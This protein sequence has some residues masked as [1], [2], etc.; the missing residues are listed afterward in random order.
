MLML[1]R[2]RKYRFAFNAT[3]IWW[4]IKYLQLLLYV[5]YYIFVRLLRTFINN[6][7]IFNCPEFNNSSR[8]NRSHLR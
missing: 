5:N 2:W 8:S 4:P 1:V 6:Y 3:L 7:Y